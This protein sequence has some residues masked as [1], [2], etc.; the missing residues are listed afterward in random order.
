MLNPQEGRGG[1]IPLRLGNMTAAG[2]TRIDDI[3]EVREENSIDG[4]SKMARPS[5]GQRLSIVSN[6][7]ETDEIKREV[8]PGTE[9]RISRFKGA[10]DVACTSTR[11]PG[12]IVQEILR[13]LE[14]LKLKY[15]KVTEQ[16]DV[17]WLGQRLFG[18]LSEGQC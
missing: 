17:L 4:D 2:R 10:F 14:R 9:T 16:S 1:R 7:S 11:P 12:E 3:T 8:E 5:A 15:R 6:K 13:V 18:E